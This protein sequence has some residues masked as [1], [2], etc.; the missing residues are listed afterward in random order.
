MCMSGLGLTDPVRKQA[1]VQ[2]SPGPLL[3]NSSEPIGSGMFTGTFCLLLLE[4]YVLV[5]TFL[6]LHSGCYV[7]ITMWLFM[8]I[9]DTTFCV[10]LLRFEYY[11]L[12]TLILTT[13]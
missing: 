13:L 4:Y 3:A 1:G 12:S 8:Y 7:P 11:V 9:V 5:P 2:Q 6:L 10:C